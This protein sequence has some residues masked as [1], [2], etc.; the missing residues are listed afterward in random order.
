MSINFDKVFLG[1]PDN[2]A[3]AV[4]Y[5]VSDESKFATSS[6]LAVDGGYTAE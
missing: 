5:L 2:V 6:E 4:L 1:K 3:H